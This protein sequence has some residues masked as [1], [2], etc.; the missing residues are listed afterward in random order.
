M[1]YQL[2]INS[3]KTPYYSLEVDTLKGLAQLLFPE[4]EF[5]SWY[6][7]NDIHR[8]NALN[9]TSQPLLLRIQ[10]CLTQ[11]QTLAT[12]PELLSFAQ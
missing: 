5:H 2:Y 4:T 7:N 3:H 8:T 10:P 6:E 9:G 12:N 1:L 11:T